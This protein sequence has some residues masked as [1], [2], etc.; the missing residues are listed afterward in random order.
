MQSQMLYQ[1][2]STQTLVAWF[3]L[4]GNEKKKFEFF[5]AKNCQKKFFPAKFKFQ[6]IMQNVFMSSCIT[7]QNDVKFDISLSDNANSVGAEISN[8]VNCWIDVQHHQ[9]SGERFVKVGDEA[10]QAK[11]FSRWKKKPAYR[12]NLTEKISK[13]ANSGAEID[14]GL[15]SDPVFNGYA[16]LPQQ[17][18]FYVTGEELEIE[19]L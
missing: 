19:K 1:L 11:I 13:L 6:M 17:G 7:W 9:I 14:Y 2:H 8:R 15:T 18:A 4:F 12:S 10:W 5:P 16:S 3:H